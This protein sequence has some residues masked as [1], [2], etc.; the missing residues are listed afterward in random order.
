MQAT[1][2]LK[3]RRAAVMTRRIK[4]IIKSVPTIEG[5]GVHLNTGLRL[6]PG[7]PA[8]PIPA[9]RRLSFGR[10]RRLHPRIPLAS[11]PGHRDDHLRPRRAASSTA[12]AWATGRHRPGDVQ[13]MT[14]GSGIIHQEMP[15]GDEEGCMWGFQLWA[16]LPASHKMMDPRYQEREEGGDPGGRARGGREDPGHM[17]GGGGREG[18]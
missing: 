2:I 3:R 13:W 10:P 17:R 8:R 11:P 9:P 15:K 16:N 1:F 6:F 18:R 5:A 7:P 14:A 4:K 12:T